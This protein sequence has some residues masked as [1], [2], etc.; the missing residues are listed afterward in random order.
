[1]RASILVFSMFAIHQILFERYRFRCQND[2][3]L[4]PVLSLGFDSKSS[5]IQGIENSH[6][7]TS[8]IT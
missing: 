1:M 5:W 6:N 8:A 4:S 3:R 7:G 2:A